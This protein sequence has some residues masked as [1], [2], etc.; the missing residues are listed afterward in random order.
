MLDFVHF[1]HNGAHKPVFYSR[2]RRR[3]QQSC[4]FSKDPLGQN[5]GSGSALHVH[6]WD[7]W[8]T[9]KPSGHVDVIFR[10]L[11][12]YKH[13]IIYSTWW[14][15]SPDDETMFKELAPSFQLIQ[16]ER[17]DAPIPR[18]E[19]GQRHPKC[20]VLHGEKHQFQWSSNRKVGLRKGL[21][22]PRPRE[23]SLRL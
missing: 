6:I 13:P 15:I 14:L 8:A 9:H 20:V 16:G 21:E 7:T 3:P 10:L 17:M 22:G 19:K 5:S 4:V 11:G 1:W 12:L 2:R 18:N 23:A